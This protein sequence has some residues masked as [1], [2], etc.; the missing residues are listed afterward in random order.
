MAFIEK[1]DPVVLNVKLTSKGRELLSSGN[2]TFNHFAL[3]DSEMDYSFNNTAC[4]YDFN[5]FCSSILKSVDTNPNTI[6]FIPQNLSGDPYNTLSTVPSISYDVINSVDS[7]GFFSNSG[8]TFIIDSNH[9][10]QPD[11][12]I[13]M[14]EITGGTTLRLRKA[15][16][17]GTSGEEPAVG[18]LVLI[19]WT[20]DLSTTGHTINKNYPTAFLTYRIDSITSGSLGADNLII[21]IDR[22]LP[23]FSDYSPVGI[24]GALIYYNYSNFTGDTITNDYSTDYLDESVLTF[25]ENSQ[26]PTT[27]F[28]FWN[29][30]IIYTHEIAGVSV[31]D[32]KFG[33]FDSRT[34]GG[35]VSYIQNHASVYKKLGVIHYTNSSP[36]NVY[37]EGFYLKTPRLEI[38][39]IMWHKSAQATMGLILTAS[40]DSKLITGLTTSLNTRYYD[41]ADPSG[42]IVGKVFVDLKLFVIEDQELLFAMS[43]KSNRSWTL[44]D[45][46]ADT[47]EVLLLTPPTPPPEPVCVTWTT[48]VNNTSIA[49]SSTYHQYYCHSTSGGWKAFTSGTTTGFTDICNT[50]YKV[51]FTLPTFPPMG[52]GMS[53][54]ACDYV[55]SCLICV[56]M[57]AGGPGTIISQCITN[58]NNNDNYCFGGTIS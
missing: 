29:M 58:I 10:K 5:P 36:A 11:A 44:P 50:G 19:K 1:R 42:N 6:S 46:S 56:K 32:R 14:S 2:L 4:T 53:I 43:H 35:F 7:I 18:D 31:N 22:N 26:S 51:S 17:Y 15:P 54:Y 55:N 20:Y 30:T 27:I 40:G 37:G 57:C 23:D 33:Q 49:I 13:Y 12:M 9:V 48:P 3:G 34:Y 41:L 52:A 25:I 47:N 24:A 16:T 21:E 28:P 39:T 38:P 45:Y 8:T